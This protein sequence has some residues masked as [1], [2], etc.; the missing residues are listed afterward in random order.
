MTVFPHKPTGVPVQVRSGLMERI[1][2]NMTIGLSRLV[3]TPHREAA[4]WGLGRPGR[5]VILWATGALIL[6]VAMMYIID[7]DSIVWARTLP[8]WF[9]RASSVV[10]DL[11]LS[12]WFLYPLGLA[13]VVI[14]FIDTNRLPLRARATVATMSVRLGFL[15]I[16]IGLPGIFVTILKHIIGRARPFVPGHADPFAYS[17]FNWSAA[18]A[19]MPS[20]HA[21]TVF[22]VAVAFGAA[23]PKLRLPLFAYAVI[24]GVSRVIVTAHHPSDVVAG[25]LLGMGTALL[26]RRWF[27]IRRLGFAAGPDGRIRPYAGPSLQRIKAVAADMFAK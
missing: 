9:R 11:G 12:G 22:A 17:P 14:A 4:Y 2:R 26:V 10:T 18:Y 5:G 8:A 21:T 1:V 7:A 23:F 24:I 27:A 19:S 20:G 6:C 3:K 16:A 13:L 25:A 15:F